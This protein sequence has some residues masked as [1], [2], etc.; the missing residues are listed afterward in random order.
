MADPAPKNHRF[1]SR[2]FISM[3]LLEFMWTYLLTHQYITGD[4]FYNLTFVTVGGYMLANV[5]D[6]AASAYQ[7]SKTGE[8]PAW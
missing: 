5:G 2:K 4:V 7:S 3:W 1:T 8:P 6:K